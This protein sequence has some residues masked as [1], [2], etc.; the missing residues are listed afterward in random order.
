MN[1]RSHN[2]RF[3]SNSLGTTA[4]TFLQEWPD[5]ARQAQCACA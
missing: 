3:A 4:L 1:I 2:A 5:A